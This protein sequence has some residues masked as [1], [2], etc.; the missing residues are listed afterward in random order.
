MEEISDEEE[1]LE[2]RDPERRRLKR[3]VGAGSSLIGVDVRN[4]DMT[5]VGEVGKGLMR[6]SVAGVVVVITVLGWT[7][8]LEKVEI[9]ESIATFDDLV[10]C[11]GF[12]YPRP[13]C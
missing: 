10:L 3:G 1:V 4:L 7:R 11:S 8:T 5:L 12:I 9:E 2:I 6:E 13:A